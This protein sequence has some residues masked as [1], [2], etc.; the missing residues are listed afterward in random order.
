MRKDDR[1][2]GSKKG[3]GSKD[4]G[5]GKSEGKKGFSKDGSFGKSKFSGD[6]GSSWS[7]K[8]PG[9][10][11]GRSDSFSKDGEKAE[12]WLSRFEGEEGKKQSW[13]DKKP[14]FGKD[15][16]RPRRARG[17]EDTGGKK[18]FKS[19]GGEGRQRTWD[20]KKPRFGKDN[21]S[22]SR[23]RGREASGDKKFFK[24]DD[25]EGKRRDWEEKK[26]RFGKEEERPERGRGREERSE[27]KSYRSDERAG[28]KK[29]W[30]EKK[31][32][33]GPKPYGKSADRYRDS[34]RDERPKRHEDKP[35]PERRESRGEENAE[36]K[37]SFEEKRIKR[38]FKEDQQ[39]AKENLAKPDFSKFSRGDKE[40]KPQR[41]PKADKESTEGDDFKSIYKG[42]GK[43]EKPVYVRV[44]KSE[45]EERTER[46][47][48][49]AYS[50][51]ATEERPNYN[52]EN[53]Q[54]GKK[55][56][57]D[58]VFRLNKYISNSGICS[59]R[60]A[61]ELIKKGDVMVNGEV[62]TEMGYKVLRSDKVTYRG[63]LIRPEK[64]VYILLNKPKDF[65]TTT[66]DPME[67][68]TVMHLIE[69]ACDERVFPVGRLDRNTTGLLLFTN[70]GEL[71]DKLSHPSNEVKKIYQVT[72]DKPLTQKHEE[73][74]MEGFTLE[75][76]P[77]NVNDMQVLSKDRT[78][79][80]LEIH[81]GRNRIVRRIFAHFGYD[82]VALDRVLYAGLDK[83]DLPR[84]R[85]RFLT[86]QEVIRLKHFNR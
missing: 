39:L 75:D 78:I 81:L 16:D 28:G 77:V 19:E 33:D 24:S 8:K 31:D 61:D 29:P 47:S 10:G 43:D 20:D 64:P 14:R 76:G 17:G 80:G 60:E 35:K 57:D 74:I 42:R 59:R 37:G 86:E 52:L 3:F 63:K 44:P 12:K 6:K 21:E 11:K 15:D 34:D 71:A 82:V 62:V 9:F 65:I 84:G 41:F 70:D 7:E 13:D 55:G 54:K 67:R 45:V 18:F 25:R 1:N 46:A 49:K 40:D 66:D 27:R 69:N 5:K 73:E 36:R 26:P 32:F 51:E 23:G 68:K 79:L 22:P 56:K 83:K 30:E 4:S 72:L 53:L 50:A 2:Y 38:F 48:K 85:Y 58:E